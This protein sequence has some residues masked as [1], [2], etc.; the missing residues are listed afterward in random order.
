MDINK[1]LK[2]YGQ[3][4]FLKVI[5]NLKDIEKKQVN[6][7]IE[8][9]DLDK[10]M[11]YLNEK[12]LK[13]I[14][15]EQI[16]PITYLEYSKIKD[17]KRYTQIGIESLK[18]N[19][20]AIVILAGGQGTRLGFNGP[21]GT[22]KIFPKEDITFFSLYIEKIKKIEKKYSCTIPLYIMTSKMN[23]DETIKYFAENQYFNRKEN[24]NFFIQDEMPMFLK[25]KN[26]IIDENRKVKF[27]S[28]GHGNVFEAM[29]KNNVISKLKKRKIKY[30]LITGLDN[31]LMKPIDVMPLGI[32]IDKGVKSIG[33]SIKKEKPDEKMGVFCKK[34]GKISVVEYSEISKDLA[35]KRNENNELVYGDAHLLW[36]IYRVDVLEDLSNKKVNYHL[37]YKKCNYMNESGEIIR[38]DQPNAYKFESFIFDFFDILNDMIIYRVDRDTEYAP[39]K[40]ANGIDSL[41]IAQEKFKKYGNLDE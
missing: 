39:I 23:N 7:V 6:K 19:E 3:N 33:K 37:A 21:K 20:Y 32:M 29:K 24:I 1:I 10:Y 9:I 14:R 41:K 36:N 13:E 4:H 35:E 30:L 5:E 28:N 31:I 22:F 17:L 15:Y 27:A 2:D 26:L 25:N 38:P 11:K 12:S 34:D 8:E 18:K 16:S 40:N